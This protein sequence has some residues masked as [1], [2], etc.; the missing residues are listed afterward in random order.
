[1]TLS[2][3]V[4]ISLW[5][6]APANLIVATAIAFPSSSLGSLLE[7]P[8]THPFYG[9]L[10][11]AMVG[12]FGVAYGWLALQPGI[13]RPLLCLGVCGKLLAVLISI[14]LFMAGELSV[15]TAAAISGDLVFVVLWSAFLYSS[16]S[17]R[18]A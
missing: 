15:V 16:R 8:E 12:L 9:M 17:R 6:S 2:S 11:G 13:D 4:R 3:A 7:L 18:G 5:I 10:S 1:V 14:S